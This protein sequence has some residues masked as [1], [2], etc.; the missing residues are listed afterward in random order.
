[1]NIYLKLEKPPDTIKELIEELF[2][3]APGTTS[4]YSVDTFNDKE[5]T[6]KQCGAGRY[7][8]VD[9]LVD[10]F[11]T[12]FPDK[13]KQELF[14][15]LFNLVIERNEIKYTP[16]LADCFEINK[17][18]ICFFHNISMHSCGRIMSNSDYN[19]KDIWESLEF[20]DRDQVLQ[21][22]TKIKEG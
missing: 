20:I 6:D 2:N 17:P 22:F 12:Y 9:D 16:Y 8:S 3:F 11:H 5:C 4:F 10:I 21:H 15:Q 19:W 13:D 1:M 7:R 14:T 18:T